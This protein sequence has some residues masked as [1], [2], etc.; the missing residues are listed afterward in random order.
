M[1]GKIRVLAA[2]LCVALLSLGSTLALDKGATAGGPSGAPSVEIAPP[3]ENA[4]DTGSPSPTETEMEDEDEPILTVH[5][6]PWG[7]FEGAAALIDLL[8]GPTSGTTAPQPRQ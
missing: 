3:A 7:F 1:S 2:I 8:F 5:T 4:D 6:D